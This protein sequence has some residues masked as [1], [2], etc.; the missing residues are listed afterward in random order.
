MAE[1]FLHLENTHMKHLLNSKNT[2]FCSRY[3]D[4]IIIIYDSTCTNPTEILQYD[5]S[6][7]SNLQLN[8]THE[9]NGCVS[10]LDLLNIR[11]TSKL[12]IEIFRKP[13][14]T[15]TTINYFSNHPS[16]H[17]L[18]ACRY[19]IERTFTL[20]LTT[21]RQLNEWET[22][23][24]I[25]HNNNI[26]RKLLLRLKQQVQHRTT[27]PPQ[28]QTLASLLNGQLHIYLTTHQENY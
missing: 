26:P 1:I 10:F 3:V 19:Y 5:N 4:D 6:I 21:D 15:D 7:H 12:E 14:T 18:A 25:A 11:K 16:E 13:T 20:P 2:V 22:I 28:L 24:L 23:L 17:K 8:P 9:T 27:Q